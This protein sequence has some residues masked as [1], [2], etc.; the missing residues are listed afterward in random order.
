MY[1]LFISHESNIWPKTT[2]DENQVTENNTEDADAGGDGETTEEP[3]QAVDCRN[4]QYGEWKFLGPCSVTCGSGIRNRTRKSY[5]P[6]CEDIFDAIACNLSPCKNRGKHRPIAHTAKFAW[7]A[8]IEFLPLLL[9]SMRTLEFCS[10]L[11][12]LR[13]CL[14]SDAFNNFVFYNASSCSCSEVFT[15]TCV[16]S[17]SMNM[18]ETPEECREAC[19][20]ASDDGCESENAVD[21]TFDNNTPTQRRPPHRGRNRQNWSHIYWNEWGVRWDD[22]T[23]RAYL[24]DWENN[25]DA[26]TKVLPVLCLMF[27]NK[28]NWNAFFCVCYNLCCQHKMLLAV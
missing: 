16:K 10:Y 3:R 1:L 20:E 9:L 18:F 21:S 8:H 12:N 15:T 28:L 24:D 13:N 7:K 5:N 23:P 4:V 27:R 14:R 2:Q 22:A 17:A 11:P 6:N 19:P 26:K 25:D